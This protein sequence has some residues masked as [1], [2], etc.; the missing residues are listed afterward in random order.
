[1]SVVR[2]TNDD[3][4]QNYSE[5]ESSPLYGGRDSM[6]PTPTQFRLLTMFRVDLEMVTN[7]PLL[8]VAPRSKE[9]KKES[10]VLDR[11]RRVG[12]GGGVLKGG[13]QHCWCVTSTNRTRRA[14]KSLVPSSLKVTLT[15]ARLSCS[16]PLPALGGWMDQYNT[17]NH[18]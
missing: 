9:M 10:G 5:D 15:P 6:T 4:D 14:V 16:V 7:R 18:D 2:H 11:Q 12:R 1:M 17:V 3:M 13:R 8:P